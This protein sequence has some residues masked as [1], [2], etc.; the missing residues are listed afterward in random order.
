[1]VVQ[2]RW[3]EGSFHLM[4]LLQAAGEDVDQVGRVVMNPVN[5]D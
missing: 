1:M 2:V 5:F 3:I 4:L